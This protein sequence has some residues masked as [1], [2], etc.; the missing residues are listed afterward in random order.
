AVIWV[1]HD[2][3]VVARLVDRVLVMYAGGL[4]ESG[5]TAAVFQ[6]PH[7]P[8]TSDLLGSLPR[9]TGEQRAALRQIPGSPP[10]P[11]DLPTGCPY[12]PRCA[13]A[14]A[15]RRRGRRRAPGPPA[16][17]RPRGVGPRRGPRTSP[18]PSRRRARGRPAPRAGPGPPRPGPPPRRFER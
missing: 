12:H 10:Q 8:Y 5:T 2:L 6:A 4:V 14:Q 1:T 11:A 16:R 13:Q 7:H 3:G 15:R 9:P 17:G 18:P